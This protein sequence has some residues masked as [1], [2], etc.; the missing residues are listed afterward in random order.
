LR[1]RPVW[2]VAGKPIPDTR[3]LIYPYIVD[4]HPSGEDEVLEVGLL[5]IG[6]HA[7]IQDDI[8]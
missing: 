5:E 3:L 1:G 8:L 4:I 2:R 7:E 6:C